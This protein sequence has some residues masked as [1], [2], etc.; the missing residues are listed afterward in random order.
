GNFEWN[1]P[2]KEGEYNI[3]ILIKEY[4]NGILLN[5]IIRDMQITIE[6]CSNDPPELTIPND[7]CVI[8]GN[9]VEFSIQAKDKN[10]DQKIALS[11]L[12]GPFNV[13]VNKALF[14]APAGYQNQIARGL[15]R[16]N[17]TCEHI[18]DIPYTIVFRAVDNGKNDTTG[19]ADLRTVRI[20]VVG[21]PPQNV[22]ATNAGNDKVKITWTYPNSCAVT[23]NDYFKGFSIWRKINSNQF[24]LDSCKPGLAGRGYVKIA[25]NVVSKSNDIYFYEDNMLENGKTHCYRIL[26]EFAL[27]SPGG[28]S[29]N[30]VA[31][32]PSDETC[33]QLKRDLPF[34]VEATVIKTD[35]STG[36]VE[37]KWIMPL[38]DDLDTLNRPG[39]Y[40]IQIA[41][42]EGIYT[43]STVF[44]P[45]PG[46]VFTSAS[47]ANF[48]DS[49]YLDIN[50]NTVVKA[51]SYQIQFSSGPSN[52]LIGISSPAST[53]YMNTKG[54]DR[55]VTLS[56]IEQVPWNNSSYEIYR[57][58]GTSNFSVIGTTNEHTY[59][60]LSVIN[61]TEYCYKIKSVGSYGIG[62][63][64]SPLT[65]FSQEKCITPVDSTPPCSPFITI[66]RDCSLKDSKGNVINDITWSV[67]STDTCFIDDI[68]AFNLYFKNNS[69]SGTYTKI[70][71]ITDLNLHTFRHIPDSGFT[72]C[73]I[74]TTVDKNKN[75]SLKLGEICPASCGL[76][77][78][79]PNTFTPNDDGKNDIFTPRINS[80]VI[81]V[82]FEVFNR[83]GELLYQTEDPSLQWDG[84]DQKKKEISDGVYYYVCKV[85]GFPENSGQRVEDRK[86]FIQVIH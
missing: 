77:Y 53:V 85:F 44:N 34:I 26:A 49:I 6:N 42:A 64:P 36:Q 70:A 2:Q 73:Y 61:N 78:E 21:P 41:K 67:K 71:T 69:I 59:N 76:D 46:A 3:A 28:N 82:K 29:Y 51:Y 39:P 30:R 83:W 62:G 12:G 38:A 66:D 17:T 31:S 84:R 19:I 43:A 50:L 56:W 80:G 65:N 35:N 79:L 7:I 58:S 74:L 32:L 33:V 45:I 8:A 10:N 5:S 68:S 86:G 63:L 54:K 14:I 55:L 24:P 11:A 27:K 15:F 47:F 18:S 40:R 57:K 9:K 23:I 4:R 25:S 22:F 13:I 1:A 72:G 20:K 37:L 48:T 75:E 16:W 52:N 60:D 81:K